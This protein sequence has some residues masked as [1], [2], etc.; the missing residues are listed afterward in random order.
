MVL[1]LVCSLG[2]GVRVMGL[3]LWVPVTVRGLG[4]ALGVHI[5]VW[6]LGFLGFGLRDCGSGYGFGVWVSGWRFWSS[7]VW[8]IHLH[9][10]G[11]RLGF[12]C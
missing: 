4:F 5:R 7:G 10:L 11:F 12:C 2:T 1:V 6:V 9:G 8:A 3:G